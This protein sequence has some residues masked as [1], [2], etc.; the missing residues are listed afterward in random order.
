[1]GGAFTLGAGLAVQGVVSNYGAGLSIIFACQFVVGDTLTVQNVSGVVTDIRLAYTVLMT[2]D[3]ERITVSN[4]EIIGQV[5]E[6]SYENR[7]VE[8][9][10]TIENTADPKRTIVLLREALQHQDCV[11]T[12]PA[13]QVGIDDFSSYGIKIGVRCWVATTRYMHSK[14]DINTVIYETLEQAAIRLSV[15]KQEIRVLQG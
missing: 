14:Y 13:I 1:M 3:G 2:E 6:N 8:T 4:K 5:L 12:E 10:F 7:L 11:A 15:P 9:I